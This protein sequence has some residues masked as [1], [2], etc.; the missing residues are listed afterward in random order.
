MRPTILLWDIDGTLIS[1]A[2][3]GRRAMERAFG[4]CLGRKDLL[5]FPFDG[6]TDQVILREAIV[7]A[8]LD[9][10]G[11]DGRRAADAIL[12]AYVDA[13][14]DEAARSSS[15]RIHPG[16]ERALDLCAARAGFANGLGTGNI[17]QGATIKLA[18]VGLDA[19]FAFGGFGDDAADRPTVLEAG[20]R[21]GAAALGAP[22]A[23]CR[24]VVIGD[25]PKDISAAHAI[26]AESIAVATGNF[27]AEALAAHAPTF[28]FA[29]L[30]EDGADEALLGA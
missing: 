26:G 2:G 30:T 29:S 21:R 11:D 12:A 22:L 8:G 27:R 23:D 7:R 17:R 13:L 1:T 18:R 14:R 5:D 15:F 3:A 19:R 20:A 9:P 6:M 28:V 16:V 4:A 25:T 10:F 24:V